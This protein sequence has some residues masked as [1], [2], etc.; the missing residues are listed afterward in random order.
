MAITQGWCTEGMLA[1]LAGT[2]SLGS[3]TLKIALYTSNASLN[4]DTT[5]Y[6]ASNEVTGT[7]YTAGGATLTGV[8]V[9]AANHVAYLS[10][11]N[12]TWTGPLTARGALVYDSS[13]SDK[14][15]FVLDFGADKTASPFT[16]TLPTADYANAILRIA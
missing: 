11:D 12:P 16:I 2:V 4:E 7:G 6:T 3:D 9:G 1:V 5:A 13:V 14:A 10:F 15:I 8:I